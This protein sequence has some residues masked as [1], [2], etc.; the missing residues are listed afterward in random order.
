MLIDIFLIVVFA[1][2]VYQGWK[3]GFLKEIISSIGFLLG[4]FVAATC[5]STLGKY[6]TDNNSQVNTATNVIAFFILWIIVPIVLG[7]VANMLTKALKGLKLGIPNSLLGALVSVIKYVILLSCIFFMME[8]FGI[9][10]LK[11][12]ESSML[13]NPAKNIVSG[14]LDGVA[15][16]DTTATGNGVEAAPNDTVWVDMTK[17]K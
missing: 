10:D 2:A 3:Q 12:V 7:L 16:S 8:A 17:K 5:Y 15:P 9:L 4:L 6:L 11:K 1:W 14:V 13:Y